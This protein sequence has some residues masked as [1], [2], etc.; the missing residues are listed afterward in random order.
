MKNSSKESYQGQAWM[1][2][3][4]VVIVYLLG[5][6]IV[7]YGSEFSTTEEYQIHDE[8]KYYLEFWS[9]KGDR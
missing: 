7:Y 1:A 4:I 5:A 8:V 3:W 6:M 9:E 2:I